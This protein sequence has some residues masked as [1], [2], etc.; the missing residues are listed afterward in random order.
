MIRK[1]LDTLGKA[2][3]ETGQALDRAGLEALGTEKHKELWSRHRQV[4]NLFDQRPRVASNAFVAPSATVVGEVEL[5]DKV[6]IW[7]GAVIRGDRNSV[8]IGNCTN[9]QDHAVITTV[10]TLDTGFPAKVDIG[11]MVTIGHGATITSATIQDKALIGIGSVVS[12]GALVETGAQLAAGSVVP[13][14]RRIPAGELWGGNP[15]KFI[16]KLEDEEVVA[17]VTA[18]EAYHA[19]ARTHENEFQP[20]GAAYLDAEKAKL[21]E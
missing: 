14:G 3:R 15:V 2:L 11:H 20:F 10:P 12:E 4:S 9:V 19:L 13:P 16:R 1:G 17:N 5:W 6:S 8:K 18:A 21:S 7:Y